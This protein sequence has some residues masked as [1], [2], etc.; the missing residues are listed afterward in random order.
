MARR[1]SIL[2]E[3][4]CEWFEM[5]HDESI[6][7]WCGLKEQMNKQIIDENGGIKKDA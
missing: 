1:N 7:M 3:Q 4:W 5:L 2:D 6:D